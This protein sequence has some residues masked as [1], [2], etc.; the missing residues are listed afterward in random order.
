MGADVGETQPYP[1]EEE[2]EAAPSGRPQRIDP[3]LREALENGQV[4]GMLVEESPD[5]VRR[6]GRRR[7]ART[8][9]EEDEEESPEKDAGGGGGRRYGLREKRKVSFKYADDYTDAE[10]EEEGEEDGSPQAGDDMPKRY[11]KR[12]RKNTDFFMPEKEDD[13]PQLKARR[14]AGQDGD[15]EVEDGDWE[16]GDDGDG[17]GL[18]DDLEDELDDLEDRR[19]PTRRRSGRLRNARDPHE[20][21]GAEPR[22]TLRQRSTV[23]RYTPTVNL[24][25]SPG[26]RHSHRAAAATKAARRRLGGGALDDD[27]IPDQN[28]AWWMLQDGLKAAGGA[29]GVGAP[30][31]DP[32]ELVP[33]GGLPPAPWAEQAAGGAGAFG[34]RKE[35]GKNAEIAPIAV[36]PNI[37]FDDIGGLGHYVQA[38]K[39]MV[40]LPLVYPDIFERFHIA[41]PR[42]VLLHGPPGTGKTLCARALAATASRTGQKVAFFMRK[43]ADILS[44]WV[45]EAERQLRLLFQEAQK[46]QP[47][48]IFFDEIDGLAPSRNGKQDQIHNSI[49]STMLALMDGLD[50]RGQVVV[51]GA[52]NRIDSL[53]SAL[54]RPGR[55]DRELLFPLPNQ[56]ARSAILDIHTRK[57]KEPP[58]ADLR[59]QLSLE[60]VGY[61]GADLKA[62][63]T[64]AALEALRR[65]Y[66]QIY[67]REERL[68]I[69]SS[70]IRVEP[71]DFRNA[72]LKITPA[73]HRGASVHSRPLPPH[74]RPGLE[75]PLAKLLNSTERIFPPS[76]KCLEKKGLSGGTQSLN[77]K[78]LSVL[79]NF[80]PQG[81]MLI[82]GAPG[83][84]QG[85][86]AA[87][88]LHA[89]EELPCH[90]IGLPELLADPSAAS[91]EAA[92][93]HLIAEAR[94]ASPAILYLPNLQLW[95]ETAPTSLQATLQSLLDDLPT[96]IPLFFLATANC[97][98][99]ELSDA[100]SSVFKNCINQMSLPSAES[101]RAIFADLFSLMPL[102][103]DLSP[104]KGAEVEEVEL[105]LAPIEKADPEDADPQISA[106]EDEAALRQLRVAFRGIVIK[107]ISEK[108]WKP[109][110]VPFTEDERAMC[111][112]KG[113]KDPMNMLKLLAKIDAK[114]YST[115]GAF[116][117][118]VNQVVE[119]FRALCDEDD[120]DD[121][122][123]MS[124]AHAFAD[125]IENWSAVV[126]KDLAQKCEDV[127][128]RLGDG[129]G[130]KSRAGRVAA[131]RRENV[132]VD[133]HKD[134]EELVRQL[135]AAKRQEEELSR[136]QRRERRGC[137][138]LAPPPPPAGHVVRCEVCVVTKKGRCGSETASRRC[139]RRL[140]LYVEKDD[141]TSEPAEQDDQAGQS[142]QD[143]Q[144][145][146]GEVKPAL[147]EASLPQAEVIP[148]DAAV[149]QAPASGGDVE[150]AP[151]QEPSVVTPG[152][153]P[154]PA[155]K[156]SPVAEALPAAEVDESVV[157]RSVDLLEKLVSRTSQFTYESLDEV[158]TQTTILLREHQG[159]QDRGPLMHAVQGLVDNCGD[160]AYKG[161]AVIHL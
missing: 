20:E 102:P 150:M 4:G 129:A 56:E 59:K 124:R 109:L 114:E 125:F 117:E 90:A 77:S 34:G 123:L 130:D 72:R 152:P 43:G 66:P 96:S 26:R 67:R 160:S 143:G 85:Y 46:M 161:H 2:P 108:K 60:C 61:C 138:A 54:R 116:L 24:D 69:D 98:A 12:Q 136:E 142:R 22:R 103:P 1:E 33:V 42:G 78:A 154:A 18:S 144:V 58:N 75:P 92:L 35:S 80:M 147:L 38:L 63:C 15:Y 157:Q 118:G 48:I 112:S 93:V 100:V 11:P 23:Q 110:V 5:N 10:S 17:E 49:V 115:L 104:Q 159:A 19:Y 41:P 32:N 89:L 101:R 137:E 7:A 140:G 25:R 71:E 8:V 84:G 133:I 28:Q 105:P 141:D 135:R 134:P 74:L 6:S 68:V 145:P 16:E 83:M 79:G 47:S 146:G 120:Q 122:R 36:D 64:E 149:A 128:E 14:E 30:G 126:P 91:P 45:G 139:L 76:V 65:R 37:S 97:P 99:G 55:F 127:A 94:R 44:K 21:A 3:A 27:L 13:L 52:T 39:E 53:D 9:V 113:L 95:W 153:G 29:G 86:V 57:W 40:F 158:Y 132:D 106:L 121:A 119:S 51:I 156:S 88:L 82:C 155:V 70:S 151:A 62:L 73:S 131:R 31:A 148:Q 87:A 81:R 107:S 111:T 50:S